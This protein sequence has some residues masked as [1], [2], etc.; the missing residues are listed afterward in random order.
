MITQQSMIHGKYHGE[1][2]YLLRIIDAGIWEFAGMGYCVEDVQTMQTDKSQMMTSCGSRTSQS[3]K[4][5][6]QTN[7]T[8][9]EDIMSRNGND[10]QHF[11]MLQSNSGAYGGPETG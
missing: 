11:R 3:H 1:N 7:C 4:S 10:E 6:R 9:Q 5:I 8:K 2:G